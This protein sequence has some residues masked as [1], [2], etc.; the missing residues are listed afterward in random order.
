MASVPDIGFL[1]QEIELAVDDLLHDE[2]IPHNST[3]PF[4]AARRIQTV[5]MDYGIQNPQDLDPWQFV[6]HLEGT[7]TEEELDGVLDCWSTVRC[8]TGDPLSE[9]ID[10]AAAQPEK[11]TALP[12]AQFRLQG[13]RELAQITFRAAEII[14]EKFGEVYLPSRKLAELLEC[15]SDTANRIT[16][17]LRNAGFLVEVKQA[18]A[19]AAARY[20]TCRERGTEVSEVYKGSEVD[21]GSEVLKGYKER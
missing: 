10:L 12:K 18:T 13:I 21:K 16:R 8:P 9:A 20:K 7:L 17:R 2:G 15:N 3:C 6:E 11:W 4:E 5:L 14:E 1:L 19:Y